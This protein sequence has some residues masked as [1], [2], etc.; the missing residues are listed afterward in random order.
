L[1]NCIAMG[2][3]EIRGGDGGVVKGRIKELNT[4]VR[5]AD[6]NER[7]VDGVKCKGCHAGLLASEGEGGVDCCLE[8]AI[9]GGCSDE[10]STGV[11]SRI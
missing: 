8:R 4:A 6:G 7:R 11:M 5:E 2:P 3:A 9:R 10:G 1:M